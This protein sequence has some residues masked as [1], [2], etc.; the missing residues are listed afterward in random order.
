VWEREADLAAAAVLADAK[1]PSLTPE[2]RWRLRRAVEFGD[3]DLRVVD[4]L[5]KP[6]I[7][8]RVGTTGTQVGFHMSAP[9][10]PNNIDTND[11]LEIKGSIRLRAGTSDELLPFQFGFVQLI[12]L[13]FLSLRYHGRKAEEGHVLIDAQVEVGT[14]LML[15][16]N[17][18][19]GGRSPFYQRP[20]S[21]V[22]GGVI[23]TAMQDHPSLVVPQTLHNFRTGFDNHLEH[24][25]ERLEAVSILIAQQP[26][27]QFRP[28]GHVQ[29]NLLYDASF[30]WQDSQIKVKLDNSRFESGIVFMRPPRD[31]DISGVSGLLQKLG[32]SM[33]PVFNDRLQAALRRVF[34]DK[35]FTRIDSDKGHPH[36]FSTFWQ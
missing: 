31:S 25:S 10:N 6:V 21:S 27:G 30:F 22:V 9:W 1:V 17:R 3:A 19:A 34:A 16:L 33:T 5:T 2:T 35:H 26:N 7:S 8:L 29:W 15:D 20:F 12:R 28:F 13:P 36:V 23:E 32:P 11:A 24:A 18:R 4:D 14:E